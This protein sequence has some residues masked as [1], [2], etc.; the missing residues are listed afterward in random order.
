MLR[1][2]PYAQGY[3]SESDEEV[4]MDENH[5]QGFSTIVVNNLR[6][7]DNRTPKNLDPAAVHSRR[8]RSKPFNN[9]CHA[10]GRFSHPAVQCDFLAK[11]AHILEY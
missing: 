10:C 3:N 9:T 7:N 1:D 11:Y 5:L 4:D 8:E 2:K 6:W